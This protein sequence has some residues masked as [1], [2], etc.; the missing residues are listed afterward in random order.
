MKKI[1]FII[2]ALISFNSQ[3]THL[4]GGEITWKCI[5]SGPDQGSYIFYVNVI[6]YN[7]NKDYYY[8]CVTGYTK[9]FLNM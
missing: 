3:A 1:I 7:L 9:T 2:F 6:N 4:M 8:N 5:K